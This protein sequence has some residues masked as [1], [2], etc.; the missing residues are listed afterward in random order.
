M[1]HILII[2]SL[3]LLTSPLFGQE[4][5]VLYR[6]W[7]G[8]IVVWKTFGDDDVNKKYEGEIK[9]GKPNGLGILTSPYGDKHVGGWKVGKRHG[10]GTMTFSSGDKYVGGWKDDKKHG[11][12]TDTS[13][14]GGKYEGEWKVGKRHGQGT[15]TVPDLGKYVGEWKNGEM[16]TGIFYDNNGNIEGKMLNGKGIE[17]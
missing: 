10:Q 2:L 3:L 5:G 11:Q 14:D 6:W 17:Q 15:L 16:W 13:S 8:K 12:G 7:D 1:K 9:N 4:T